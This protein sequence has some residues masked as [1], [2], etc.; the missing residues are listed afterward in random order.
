[1]L[2]YDPSLLALTAVLLLAFGVLYNILV[3]WLQKQGYDE[4]YTA[5]EVVGGVAVSLLILAL[6]DWQAALITLIA[7]CFSGLP[8]VIGSIWR[9]AEARKRGQAA[10]RREVSH[11]QKS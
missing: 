9:Y 1:M 11:D 4:G 2:N 10:Q 3:G 5:L 7:F 6:A 8:M